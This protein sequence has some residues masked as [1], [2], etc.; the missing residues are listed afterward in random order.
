VYR[1][2]ALSDVAEEYEAAMRTFLVH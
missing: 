2:L 1:S